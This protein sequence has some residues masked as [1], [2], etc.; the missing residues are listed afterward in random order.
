MK[1]KRVLSFLLCMIMLLT[2][3][4]ASARAAGAAAGVIGDDLEWTYADGALTITGTGAM[5][6][7]DEGRPWYDFREEI[8]SVSIGEG[9]TTIANSAFF[10]CSSL[11]S[12]KLPEGLTV[13]EDDA[14]ENCGL[15]ADI[16]LPSTLTKIGVFAFYNDR[17][18]KKMVIPEGVTTI[19]F[20]AFGN[21]EALESVTIPKTATAIAGYVFFYC[22]SL[23]NAVIPE[24]VKKINSNTFYDCTSLEWIV[25]P[26]SLTAI[27]NNSFTGCTALQDVYFTGTSAQMDKLKEKCDPTDNEALLNAAWHLKPVIKTQPAAKA[28]AVDKSVTF[29]MTAEG[30]GMSY[31]WQV[32]KSSAGS[33]TT[34]KGATSASYK[35]TAKST[36][37]GY[38]YR[39]KVSNK[40]GSVYSD[41]AKLTVVTAKPKITTQPTHKTVKK[42]AA[43]T[44]KVAASGRALS[45]QWQVKKSSAGSWT[46]I[47]GATSASYKLTAKATQNGYQYRCAVKNAMGTVYSKAA[48]LTVVTTAPKI[49]TQPVAKSV[50]ADSSVTFKV[51]A[52]GTA[53]SYQ[54]QYRKGTSGTWTTIKGATSA[55][56]KIAKTT[57]KQNGYYYRCVVKNL[58]GTATSKA[59][60]LTVKKGIP[61][62]VYVTKTGDK[63]HVDGCSSLSRSKIAISYKDAVKKGYTPCSKCIG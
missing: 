59:V 17:S 7:G 29:K 41:A 5:E 58:M 19:G 27:E 57:A 60:K 14:F 62:T 26:A 51:A 40:A 54:W 42:G 16:T 9:V 53:L 28:A 61:S 39:C 12:A 63:Y 24:G 37:N 25:L 43:V 21:C 48:K 20:E 33:W 55:V 46:N 31:Q 44:F 13:I 32:K 36:Q 35:L 1:S 30:Y 34:I 11:T 49:T 23:K 38:Q 6:F 3:F 18:L 8:T 15:L 22:K 2:L 50:K 45:Y 52:S 47:K 4:P 56:Y 10:G